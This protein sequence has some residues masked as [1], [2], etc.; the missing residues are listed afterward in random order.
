[1]GD[2]GDKV[3]EGTKFTSLTTI[4]PRPNSQGDRPAVRGHIRVGVA[5]AVV[6]FIEFHEH[7][8]SA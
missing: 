5:H 1:M 7:C 3:M 6:T 2:R 4:A 8:N